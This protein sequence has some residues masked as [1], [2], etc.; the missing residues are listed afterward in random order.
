VTFSYSENDKVLFNHAPGVIS[1]VMEAAGGKNLYTSGGT[2]HLM[3]ECRM[4]DDLVNRVADPAGRTCDIPNLWICD[5]SLM[6]N[7]G[8]VN[9]SLTIMANA[10][11]I[12]GRIRR[13]GP[14]MDCKG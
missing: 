10:A 4:G 12:A 3:G 13:L 11:R 14:Q 8:G 2:A 5:G 7:G 6:P 9:S 1:E